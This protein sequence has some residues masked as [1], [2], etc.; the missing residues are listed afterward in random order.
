MPPRLK[1]KYKSVIAPKLKS[2]FKIA[3][4][5]AVPRLQ[6]VILNVGMG[7][8]IEGTKLN[9]KAKE[10]VLKDLTVIA[11]QKPVI[12]IARK[13]VANFKL[14]AGFEVGATVTLRGD[15]MWEF[16]DRLIS[17]AIPRIKDFRGLKDKSFDKQGNYSFGITEQG[18]FPEVNM[19]DAQFLHGMHITFTFANSD[20]SKS[21]AALKE[22]G[23]PF[24]RPDDQQT[25]QTVKKA[26]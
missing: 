15:R 24:V 4:V 1:E 2:D 10:Q 19:A 5:M 21:L 11:G 26:S 22:L 7:K 9:V 25:R 14:R 8:Q 3:N 20:P 6:K 18:I 12:N 17:V 23:V 13:S 16:V